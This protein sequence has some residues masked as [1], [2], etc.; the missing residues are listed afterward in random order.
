MGIGWNFPS[1]NFAQLNGI[2]E[3]GIETFR[4]APYSSLAREISQNSLDAILDKEKPVIVE[5]QKIYIDKYEIPGYEEL[6]DAMERCL[7][8]WSSFNNKKATDFFE[9][10]CNVLNR[11][12]ISVL[13]ISDFNTIGLTGSDKEYEITPWQ[14]LVKSSGVS[15]KSGASGGSFGIGKSAPFACL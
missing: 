10:S 14:S 11:E 3:A 4:G 1:N 6:K 2:S 12:K 9:N 13:R 15:D 5:F 8:F 7:D